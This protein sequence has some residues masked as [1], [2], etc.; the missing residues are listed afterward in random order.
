MQLLEAIILGIVQGLTEFLPISSSAHLRIVG[1]FL[2]SAQDPGAT[3]TAITQIGTE[4]AVLVYFWKKIT[5]IIG[6]WFRS[7]SGS[8]PRDDADVRLGWIVIIGTLPIGVL[9]FL[10]Q[11]VIRDTFRNLWLVAIVLIVFGLILGAADALGRRVRTEKDLTY[12]HGLALGFAQALALI[13]GVSRSGA[14]TTMGLALGY[15]RPAAAEVAFLLA[16]PAV[17]GS[18]LYELLQA[19]R[20]PG[21]SVFSLVDTA[22]AT[23]VAFGVGLA[24]IAFLMQYL[25]RGSFLPFVLYRV[26]LGALLII[27][28]SLGVLQ[29]Y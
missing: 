16:V 8:V 6:R 26:G 24:V 1:E 25:K 2:P 4:L 23:V 17:F 21:A 9:G 14:T 15:T 19:I 20:E 11:D 7:F 18:G 13:P 28:L 29:A 3:F 27:L 22:V 5:R 10:F 12:G